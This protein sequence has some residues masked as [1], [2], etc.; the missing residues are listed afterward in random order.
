MLTGQVINPY[1]LYVFFRNR[2]FIA[3]EQMATIFLALTG[4]EAS[5]A[6]LGHFT[7]ASI[8]VGL[9]PAL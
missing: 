8:R 4:A 2:Q 6:D 7:A 3:W 9:L 5:Y 1:Y